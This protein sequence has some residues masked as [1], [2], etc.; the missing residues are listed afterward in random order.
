MSTEMTR[1]HFLKNG[2]LVL[3]AAAVPGAITLMNCS[4][5]SGGKGTTFQPHAFLE[6]AP[7]ESVTVWLGQTNLGQ[8]THTGIPMII[9]EELD[10]DWEKVRS[11]MALAAEPFKDP[12]WH[13]QVTAGSTSIRN[14]WDLLRTVGAAARVMLL[15]A[16]AAEWGVSAA[17]C[18]TKSGKV[19]GPGGRSRSY[20][21]LVG[22][23]ATMPVPE[24]PPL[25]AAS[26]YTIIGSE[27][28]RLDLVDKV[29]G[30]TVYGL[31]MQVPDM[32]I[33]VLD[34]PPRYGAKPAAYDEKAAMAVRGV[35]KIVTLDDKVAVC[36]TSTYAA[37]QGR[38]ALATRWSAGSHPDL[39]NESISA[40]FDKE[41]AK[42]GAVEQD[43]GDTLKA[44]SDAA[45]TVEASY[46]VPYVSHAQLE[47]TNCTAFVEKDR[48]RIWAP[49]QA[50]TWALM[51][52]AST[53]GLP[54][55][56]IEIATTACG[57]GFGR[58]SET[59]VIIEAVSLSKATGRPVKVMWTREDD[60]ADDVYRPGSVCQI[61][62]GLDRAGKPV[63]WWHKI[64][65][66]SI[67]A[68]ALP[69]R[70]ENGIDPMSVE[71]V[72]DMPYAVPNR[73]VE[74]V[75]IHLPIRVGFLRSV[76]HSI[77]AFTV[78]SFMDEMAH[79]AGKDPVRFRLD[80][81][82]TDSRTHKVLSTLAERF[83]WGAPVP[84]G[85]GRGVALSH[86]FESVVA[87]MAEVSVDRKTGGITV[88]KMSCVVDCGRAIYPDAVVAQMEGGIVMGMSIALK[89]EMQF[90][91]GGVTT[92][93]YSD[94]SLLSMTEM[95]EI[96]VHILNSGA[97]PGG[98]GEPGLPTVAPAISNAVFAATGV[99][100]RE[101][102]F[103]RNA[104]KRA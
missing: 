63:A 82:E 86:C 27:R 17:R 23:A 12:L 24:N 55:E 60:F 26:E 64:A 50:Q 32:L 20:G 94:Y 36:A 33:A 77:N 99:R 61:K 89:E 42:P 37:L 19:H 58:R 46:V 71:G 78:E 57:G 2:C 11:K 45:V 74:Y 91:D 16:A 95:P 51:A 103:R 53:T 100:L 14:R 104:L 85:R 59:E 29:Q 54:P 68:R 38:E 15:E 56:K 93:N 18:S 81:L 48:C 31:D 79:K 76:G 35:E 73:H 90:A 8:G 84:A 101:M 39:S 10:A 6:I 25:K 96:E 97:K 40:L 49:T 62:G 87:H 30:L 47:P 65:S 52:A 13:T 88:H 67:M 22:K 28:Q 92:S 70:V 1:R 9:A 44:L 21:K 72:S 34:R 41:M 7:D 69:S 5:A 3:A 80:Q 66:Q 4:P 98:V 83:G 43:V 75:M 102:P